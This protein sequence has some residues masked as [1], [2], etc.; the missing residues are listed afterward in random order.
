MPA[1][2]PFD[3]MTSTP[4]LRI[5]VRLGRA[6][7]LLALA[8]LAALPVW[9]YVAAETVPASR[10]IVLAAFAAAALFPASALLAC[11]GLLPLSG[12]L[13]AIVGST[14]LFSLGEPV[15]LACLAG[16]L[17]RSAAWPGPPPTASVRALRRPA[18]V[19]AVVVAASGIV[20]MFVVQPAVDYHWPFACAAFSAEGLNRLSNAILSC[21]T[22]TRGSPKTPATGFSVYWLTSLVSTS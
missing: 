21:N 1:P 18:L 9:S 4:A 12:P 20:E 2:Q 22:F 11:A 14:T 3:R 10:A 15:V 8:L 5:V 17:L 13:S 7:A 19:L 16:W 6:V